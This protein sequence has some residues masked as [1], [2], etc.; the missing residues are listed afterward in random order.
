[1]CVSLSVSDLE[2]WESNLGL[3]NAL[4]GKVIQ[5]YFWNENLEK[6]SKKNPSK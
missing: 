1:M 4:Q 5:V 2:D 3:V 6:A